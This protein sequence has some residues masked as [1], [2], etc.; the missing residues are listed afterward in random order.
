MAKQAKEAAKA[1]SISD[2]QIADFIKR[3]E[4][5][6]RAMESQKAKHMSACKGIRETI[7]GIKQEAKEAGLPK[8]ALNAAL[9]RR[10]LRQKFEAA[11]ENLENEMHADVDRIEKAL[12][13]YAS[14]PLGAAAVANE[15][16]PEPA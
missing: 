15:A 10:A 4:T 11:R 1:N 13:D 16:E 9:K 12:G 7:N 8:A 2:D 6:N 5:E 14:T 3:I